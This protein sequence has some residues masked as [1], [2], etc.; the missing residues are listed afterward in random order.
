MLSTSSWA[1]LAFLP[2]AYGCESV[3]D[4]AALTPVKHE[5]NAKNKMPQKTSILL[6]KVFPSLFFMQPIA[7]LEKHKG[8]L[9]ESK[10][11]QILVDLYS[12]K[13]HS[14]QE[15]FIWLRWLNVGYKSFDCWPTML[16]TLS[17][18]WPL[19]R[20]FQNNFLASHWSQLYLPFHS[21]LCLYSW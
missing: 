16:A 5:D 3:V 6:R 19:Y 7:H 17:I 21:G 10:L 15:T 18:F 9:V 11:F 2:K 13:I 8:S 4:A 12:L 1:E 20:K 14:I